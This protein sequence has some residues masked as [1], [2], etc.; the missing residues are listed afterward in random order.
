MTLRCVAF[1]MITGSFAFVGQRAQAHLGA[2]LATQ[3]I[4]IPDDSFGAPVPESNDLIQLRQ[5]ILDSLPKYLSTTGR[6]PAPCRAA[7]GSSLVK[8]LVESAKP[9]AFAQDEEKRLCIME[10][11]GSKKLLILSDI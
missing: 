4:E 11:V 3:K 6:N 7:K 1:A 8:N 5:G 9:G 10:Y 2:P